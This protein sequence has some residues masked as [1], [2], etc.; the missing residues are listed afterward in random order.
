MR[1]DGLRTDAEPAPDLVVGAAVDD[2]PD[3]VELAFA[4]AGDRAAGPRPDRE[5]QAAGGDAAD[6][7]EQLRDRGGLQDEPGGSQPKRGLRVLRIV[8]RG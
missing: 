8:V 5:R 7:V 6:R 3:D 1:L 4:Q 2:E